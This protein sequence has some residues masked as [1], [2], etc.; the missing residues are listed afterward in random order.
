VSIDLY[1]SKH[2]SAL[3]ETSHLLVS[4]SAVSV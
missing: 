4:K 2:S 1:N 3:F